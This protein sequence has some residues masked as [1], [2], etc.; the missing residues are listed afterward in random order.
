MNEKLYNILKDKG[1]KLPS[2]DDFNNKIES[3]E[4]FNV[5]LKKY[6]DQNNLDISLESKKKSLFL[7]SP[8]QE[9]STEFQDEDEDGVFGTVSDYLSNVFSSF[10]R[11]YARGSAAEE[12]TDIL[13]PLAEVD[14]QQIA[15]TEKTLEVLEDNKSEVLKDFEA[16]GFGGLRFLRASPEM[17]G[18]VLGMMFRT[19]FSDK[20]LSV[21]AAGGATAGAATLGVGAVPAALGSTLVASSYISEFGSTV[22]DTIREKTN[23]DGT[24]KY[25]LSDP[26]DLLKAFSDEKLIA[27]AKQN[28]QERGIPVAVL[29]ALTMKATGA[30]IRTIKGVGKTANIKRAV[31]GTLVESTGGGA[32]EAAAQYFDKGE[33]EDGQSIALEFLLESVG[34]S[35]VVAYNMLTAEKI[36][37]VQ[38]KEIQEKLNTIRDRSFIETDPVVLEQLSTLRNDLVK[39]KNINN[40]KTA[41]NLSQENVNDSKEITDLVKQLENTKE[42]QKKSTTEESRKLFEDQTKSLE[43]DIEFKRKILE[44]TKKKNEFFALGEKINNKE[45]LTDQEQKTYDD[46]KDMVDRVFNLVKKQKDKAGKKIDDKVD[47]STLNDSDKNFLGKLFDKINFF[48]EFISQR[49][50]QSQ[51]LRKLNAI[52]EIK[53]GKIA[54]YKNYAVEKYN[55]YK[56]IIDKVSKKGQNVL[57][58]FNTKIIDFALQNE[59]KGKVFNETQLKQEIKNINDANGLDV[60]VDKTVDLVKK[61]M[62]EIEGLSQKILDNQIYQ[63]VYGKKTAQQNKKRKEKIKIKESELKIEK[64]DARKKILQNEIKELKKPFVN[65]LDVIKENLGKYLTRS[66]RFFSDKNFKLSDTKA[67]ALK[68]AK[69][70]FESGFIKEYQIKNKKNPKGKDF[71][72]IMEK[73]ENKANDYIDKLEGYLESQRPNFKQTLNEGISFDNVDMVINPE[74]TKKIDNLNKSLGILQKRKDLDSILRTFLGEY[75]DLGSRYVSSIDKMTKLQ[76]EQKFFED[77]VN[78]FQGDLIQDVKPAEGDFKYFDTGSP[79]NP[80]NGKFIDSKLFDT[81]T[82]VEKETTFLP[83][84]FLNFMR[85]AKTVWNPPNSRKNI[86]GNIFAMV[87]NGYFL[88]NE[89]GLSSAVVKLVRNSTRSLLTQDIPAEI[90][91]IF[92]RAS[93]QGLMNQ[94]IGLNNL[95][96]EGSVILDILSN[97]QNQSKLKRD[98]LSIPGR[99]D[100]KLKRFYGRVDD[101]AKM[102][103]FEMESS[104]KS[105]QEFGVKYSELTDVQK[106]SIDKA[107]AE[108]VKNTFPTWSRIPD[109]YKKGFNLSGIDNQTLRDY[110][111][112]ALDL[113]ISKRG[114]LGDFVPFKLETLRTYVNSIREIG[115]TAKKIKE[116]RNQIKQESDT[117]KLEKLKVR[118]DAYLS[119]Y[120]RRLTGSIGIGASQSFM[121]VALPVL[122]VSSIKKAFDENEQEEDLRKNERSYKSIRKFYPQWMDGHTLIND[123]NNMSFNKEENRYEITT[124]DYSL[125]NPYSLILD[126]MMN[127]LK[128]DIDESGFIGTLGEV[129]DLVEP[130]ML[131]KAISEITRGQDVYG[132]EINTDELPSYLLKQIAPPSMI[133]AYRNT[134]DMKEKGFTLGKLTDTM[135]ESLIIRDYVFSPDQQFSFELRDFTKKK[136]SSKTK[137]ELLRFRDLYQSSIIYSR[138]ENIPFVTKIRER[139]KNSR[140]S[141][142]EKDFILLG[143]GFDLISYEEE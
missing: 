79:T 97:D 139:I 67:D 46:N 98:F 57:E 85:K 43:E 129:N 44:N 61:M 47:S 40:Q 114:F 119:E 115:T 106:K 2:L 94:S 30:A 32:G 140:L 76:Y 65:P 25:D 143:V 21:G 90:K 70:K 116:I 91:D 23:E 73:A 60:D 83:P 52:E 134:M 71:D 113:T 1:V 64:D 66:Y 95:I 19:T 120:R 17:F 122:A 29:D 69:K 130:N 75:K 14:Y 110:T 107:A 96:N 63:N 125:E 124:F 104:Q 58:D 39:Q 131:L 88:K 18:E 8:S 92:S 15:E 77:I 10:K 135:V 50:E 12:A 56:S 42:A 111:E 68:E 101:F 26:T 84:Y 128:G 9:T 89:T 108:K 86:T 55:E 100:Q 126:P 49:Y 132:N 72:E 3:D 87:Q 53:E 31:T 28:G 62:I 136:K 74:T 48:P 117:N 109:W 99:L 24:S 16:K 123:F 45:T 133:H 105:L 6:I 35:P 103:A 112:S 121:K 27:E 142:A 138:N 51:E 4:N 38:N 36:N 13:N 78:T 93:K 33:I 7:E 22:L 141:K 34:G 11:G 80:L 37:T 41:E 59:I 82:R 81:L 54:E 20:A 102:V 118:E 5:M 127:V 137:E